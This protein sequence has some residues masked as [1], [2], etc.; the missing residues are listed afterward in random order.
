MKLSSGVEWAMHCCL[1][2]SQVDAPLPASRLAEFHGVSPTYLAKHLQAL[3]RAGLVR[4]T[5]G[6]VG[7]YELTRGA[8]A[9]TMLDVVR[10]IDGDEPAFRCT[11]I[12][13]RGPLGAPPE[14]CRT[15]C[16]IHA[17]MAAA[18]TAWRDSLAA[19]SIA[20]LAGGLDRKSRGTALPRMREWVATGA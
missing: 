13:R 14:R 2:L 16:G 6:Q 12:R 19:V 17:A 4:S 1:V 5:Q 11:E 18:E 9:I 10:A 7:G 8:D 20:D 3:A 15:P